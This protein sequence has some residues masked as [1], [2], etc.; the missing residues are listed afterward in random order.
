MTNCAGA[1]M[2]IARTAL[3]FG[4]T[5]SQVAGV[6]RSHAA[7]DI[8]PKPRILVLHESMEFAF[9]TIRGL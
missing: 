1:I 3:I 5:K 9:S 4:L 2:L 8:K 6:E 7:S